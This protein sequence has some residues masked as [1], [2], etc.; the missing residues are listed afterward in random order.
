MIRRLGI[1]TEDDLAPGMNAAIRGATRQALEHKCQV[2]GICDDEGGLVAGSCI[3]L[4]TRTVDGILHLGGTLLGHIDGKQF[5]TESGRQLVL[6]YLADSKIDGL[7]VIGGADA[8]AAAEA[9][10]RVGFPVTSVAATVENDLPG[11]DVSL[12]VDTAMNVAIETIERMT[13]AYSTR[14]GAFIV[15]VAGRHCGYLALACAVAGGAEAVAIPEMPTTPERLAA[16]IR[17]AHEDGIAHPLVI[18]AEGAECNASRLWSYF[19][20]EGGLA[21]RPED[22]RLAYQQRAAVPSAADRLLGTRL[23]ARAVEAL[24]RGET[25]VMIG[26]YQGETRALPL[27]EV[28]EETRALD[29]ELVEIAQLFTINTEI[30]VH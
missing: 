23:G 20:K 2:L 28:V 1:L 22:A 26:S 5:L 15:E 9:L 6:R 12:G 24:L 11:V 7:V 8:Q 30:N 13:A 17:A 16:A 21:R 19:T 29:A 3:A 14:S 4:T 25:G 18:A 27:A 10:A